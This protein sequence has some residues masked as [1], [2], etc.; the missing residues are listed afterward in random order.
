MANKKTQLKLYKI[1]DSLILGSTLREKVEQIVIEANSKKRGRE[2]F[3]LQKLSSDFNIPDGFEFY[4]YHAIKKS[5]PG[6]VDSW[7]SVLNKDSDML[8]SINEMSSFITF[9]I[10]QEK[11]YVLTGGQGNLVFNEYVENFF[12]LNVIDRLIISTQDQS[13][14]G[15]K[16]TGV[17]GNV[18]TEE[19]TFYDLITG[20]SEDSFETF[21]RFLKSKL[22]PIIIKKYFENLYEDGDYK[23]FFEGCNYFLIK[24]SISIDDIFYLVKS[25][26]LIL[27]NEKPS[28]HNKLIPR[29]SINSDSKLIHALNSSLVDDLFEKHKIKDNSALNDYYLSPKNIEP[30][31]LENSV[32]FISDRKNRIDEN[33]KYEQIPSVYEYI[34]YLINL[35]KKPKF[36]LKKKDF[37]SAIKSYKIF[38]RDAEIKDEYVSFDFL[39]SINGI[40]KF[41]KKEYFLFEGYWYQMLESFKEYIDNE[42]KSIINNKKIFIKKPQY[43]HDW[44]VNNE[45]QYND[46]YLNDNNF[47]FAHRAIKKDASIQQLDNDIEYADL[48]YIKDKSLNLIH[49]KPKCDGDMRISCAQI[50]MCAQKINEINGSTFFEQYY[51]LIIKRKPSQNNKI[52]KQDFIK[53]AKNEIKISLLISDN[54]M[55]IHDM[56]DISIYGKFYL[57]KTVKEISKLGFG[58]NFS[59]LNLK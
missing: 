26:S 3:D 28:G 42:F 12:G 14:V 11:L 21:F 36:F 24:K 37:S 19:K 41:G 34:N 50:L 31:L 27:D 13:I 4:V 46:K 38:Y 30:Y 10:F 44:D 16:K 17:T 29:G 20:S 9:V 7:S 39:T 57:I 8:K 51:D 45:D 54:R 23:S 6:W 55:N 15:V 25:I 59:I 56:K 35:G 52:S 40:I 49:V 32:F 1:D 33:Q 53:K 22:N 5:I 18:K 47:L 48:I 58:S 2:K 43:I